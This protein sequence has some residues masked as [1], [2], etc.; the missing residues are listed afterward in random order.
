MARLESSSLF[1]TCL[2]CLAARIHAYYQGGPLYANNFGVP[3]RNATYDF[4]VV[5]GGTGGLATAY[6]LAENGSNT[7]AVI[8]AGGFYEV[9]NGNTS[10]VPNLG[11]VYDPVQLLFTHAWPSVDWGLV[12]TNQ[13]GLIDQQYHYFRGKTLGGRYVT[14]PGCKNLKL[15]SELVLL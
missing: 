4:V 1:F 7:V 5:G 6:R 11:L 3:G 9:D 12:T 13:T 10:V 15:S 2:F 8:E 14:I